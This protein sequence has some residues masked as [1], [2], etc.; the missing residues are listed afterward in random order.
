MKKKLFLT[1]FASPSN[2]IFPELFTPEMNQLPHPCITKPKALSSPADSCPNCNYNDGKGIIRVGIEQIHNPKPR[3]RSP[4]NIDV[5]MEY[6]KWRRWEERIAPV[7][8]RRDGALMTQHESSCQLGWLSILIQNDSPCL[9]ADYY[10][11]IAAPFEMDLDPFWK[12]A[13][14]KHA[15]TISS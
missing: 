3:E 12:E 2:I 7:L 10:L 14:S 4:I 8:L 9:T 6:W 5:L 15:A 1:S 13:E 11:K